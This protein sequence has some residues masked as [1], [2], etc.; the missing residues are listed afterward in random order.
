MGG[1]QTQ[2]VV[3]RFAPEVTRRVKE[4]RWHHAQTITDLPSGGCVLTVPV[5]HTIE[6]LPW[7]RGWAHNVEVLAPIDLRARVADEAGKVV[8]LYEEKN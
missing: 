7:I 3:L 1:Q 4:S 5:S 8:G 2:D 6:M